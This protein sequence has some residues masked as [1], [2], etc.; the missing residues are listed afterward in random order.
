[1]VGPLL[2]ARDGGALVALGAIAVMWTVVTALEWRGHIGLDP[3][4]CHMRQ[5]CLDEG[6]QFRVQ[7]DLSGPAG[8]MRGHMLQQGF[9]G[10]SGTPPKA[11]ADPVGPEARR[12]SGRVARR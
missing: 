2:W 7:G 9:G 10:A 4:E 8:T 6:A 11:R 12:V 1:M 3:G 5:P